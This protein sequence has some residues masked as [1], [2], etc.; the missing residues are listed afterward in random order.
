MVTRIRPED[1][2]ELLQLPRELG[3]H[4]HCVPSEA[5]TTFENVYG[6]AGTD[7][8]QQRVRAVAEGFEPDHVGGLHPQAW[9]VGPLLPQ[10]IPIGLLQRARGQGGHL[11]LDVQ[12]L[13]RRLDGE[14]VMEAAVGAPTWAQYAHVLKASAHEASLITDCSDAFE[15]ARALAALGPEEVLVTWGAEGSAVWAEGE[16]THVPAIPVRQPQDPTG[17]GDTYLAAYIAARLRGDA[18]GEAARFAAVAAAAKLE[19]A[20]PLM[21]DA[22]SLRARLTP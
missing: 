15:Q 16:A 5:T 19:H 18:P 17:C 8:R 7:D 12:G 3:V 13:L 21:L 22:A 9:L 14:Q 2:H 1:A 4:V 20:G 11:A 6:V 10:D